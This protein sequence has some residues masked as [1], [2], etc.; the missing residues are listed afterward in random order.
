MLHEERQEVRTYI[1]QGSV[2]KSE[3]MID[4]AIFDMRKALDR[5]WKERPRC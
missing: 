5:T 4:L 3:C 2:G 1:T